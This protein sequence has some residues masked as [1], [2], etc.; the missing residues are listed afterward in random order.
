ML[1][2]SYGIVPCLGFERDMLDGDNPVVVGFPKVAKE[3]C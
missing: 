1:V 2:K 3:K